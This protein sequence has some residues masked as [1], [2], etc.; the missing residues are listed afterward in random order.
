M[1]VLVRS[2]VK[3]LV[4]AAD[5]SVSDEGEAFDRPEAE[6]GGS[7]V[8]AVVLGEGE[9]FAEGAFGELLGG[10]DVAGGEL[11]AALEGDPGPDGDVEESGVSQ[12]ADAKELEVSGE[13]VKRAVGD[14]LE[15]VVAFHTSRM[16]GGVIG[17]GESTEGKNGEGEVGA[18]DRPASIAGDKGLE[19]AGAAANGP[20]SQ[21]VEEEGALSL[22]MGEAGVDGVPAGNFLKKIK[23]PVGGDAGIGMIPAETIEGST[24]DRRVERSAGAIEGAAGGFGE[25]LPAALEEELEAGQL[26]EAAEA[27][28]ILKAAYILEEGED[29]ATGVEE[30]C[31]REGGAVLDVAG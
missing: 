8:Q 26:N 5:F 17:E 13:K 10:A 14:L 20:G 1:V 29:V 18:G 31:R 22:G 3:R 16:K 24:S 7:G 25:I 19:V 30:I 6:A 11:V 23:A 21:L 4:L 15:G 27:M 12:S 2:G 28:F 9:A